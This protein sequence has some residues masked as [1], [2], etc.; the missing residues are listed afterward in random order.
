MLDLFLS[1]NLY[2]ETVSQCVA[3]ICP[4][5]FAFLE[6]KNE[7]AAVKNYSVLKSKQINGCKIIVDFVG[8]KSKTKPQPKKPL[9]AGKHTFV[10]GSNSTLLLT[11]YPI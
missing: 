6:F 1:E 11:K 10:N 8:V 4:F 9:S 2:S 5:R 3:Y 7:K